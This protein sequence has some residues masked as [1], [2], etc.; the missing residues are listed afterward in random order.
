MVIPIKPFSNG[1]GAQADMPAVDGMDIAVF[2]YN[3]EFIVMRKREFWIFTIMYLFQ[4]NRI[5]LQL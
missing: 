3:A 2:R 5:I 1:L 4:W